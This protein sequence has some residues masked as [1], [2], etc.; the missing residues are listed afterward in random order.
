M[1]NFNT[2]SLDKTY[3]ANTYARTPVTFV[4]GEGSVL[5][6]DAGKQ[7]IDFGSGIAVN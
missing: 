2:Q 1:S 3:I 7:Y 5:T 6:D 4:A